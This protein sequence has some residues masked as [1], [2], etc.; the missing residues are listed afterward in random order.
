MDS[1]YFVDFNHWMPFSRQFEVQRWKFEQNLKI[2]KS[3][4]AAAFDVIYLTSRHLI[5]IV[6]QA[7]M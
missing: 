4:K 5:S 3:K 6:V 7:K 2:K 1:N